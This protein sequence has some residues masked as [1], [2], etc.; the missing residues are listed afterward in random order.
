METRKNII[1]AFGGSNSRENNMKA[2]LKEIRRYE[3]SKMLVS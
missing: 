3:E 1:D 2:K